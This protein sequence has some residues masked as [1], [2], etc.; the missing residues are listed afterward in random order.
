MTGPLTGIVVCDLTR[1]VAGPH[2]TMLLGDLGARVIKVEQPGAGDECRRWGPPFAGPP[3]DQVSTYFLSCNRNK[4]SVTCDLKSADGKELLTR[5]VRHSDVLVENF[6]PGIIDRF[7]FAP[8][9]LHELNPRLVICSISGFGHDGPERGRPGYDQIVQGEAGLMSVTGPDRDHPSKAG[10][11]VADVL[12][13]VNAAVGVIA[14]LFE[15]QRTGRGSVVRTSLL[16][17][18]VGAHGYQGTRWTVAGEVPHMTGNH[19]PSIAPYGAFRCADGL[20]QIGV[21]NEQ[22]WRQFAPI[23]GLDPD[24]ERF[25]VNHVRVAHRDELTAEIEGRLAGA[26]RGH[27]LGLLASAGVPA[28]SIRTI[29]EVY[30]WE[31]TRTQGL[32]ITVQHPVLGSIELPGPALRFEY[33]AADTGGPGTAGAGRGGHRDYAPPPLLGQHD[34]DVRA[35]LDE[36]DAADG[37]TAS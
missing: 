10:L 29:D 23:A 9:R 24:D 32:V 18:V 35:W 19:H 12:A 33:G 3:D 22:Q 7:G 20:I 26:N 15:C 25:E 34:A 17:S 36:M 31:Q 21:A 14:A 37:R 8:A 28:G 6:R 13:G 1:A 30:Q 4:E 5:L 27:W 16:A 11:S 2:T